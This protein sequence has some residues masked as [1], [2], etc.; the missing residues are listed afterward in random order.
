MAEARAAE[1]VAMAADMFL[2]GVQLV[3]QMS[4]PQHQEGGEL[5]MEAL[6]MKLTAMCNPLQQLKAGVDAT[7][8]NNPAITGA[9]ASGTSASRA[10]VAAAGEL[11]DS[12]APLPSMGAKEVWAED[13]LRLPPLDCRAMQ[14]ALLLPAVDVLAS[15]REGRSVAVQAWV[16]Q[17]TLL[18]ALWVRL[19]GA[20]QGGECF[21]SAARAAAAAAAAGLEAETEAVNAAAAAGVVLV[22]Q[23]TPAEAYGELPAVSARRAAAVA[24]AAQLSASAVASAAISTVSAAASAAA[25]IVSA[26]QR[27]LVEEWIDDDLFGRLPGAATAALLLPVDGAPSVGA[28]FQ[29]QQQKQAEEKEK[30]ELHGS[31]ATRGARRTAEVGRWLAV[32]MVPRLLTGSGFEKTTRGL[33]GTGGGTDEAA[34]DEDEEATVLAAQRPAGADAEDST[35]RAQGQH[36]LGLMGSISGDDSAPRQLPVSMALGDASLAPSK[37]WSSTGA[38]TAIATAPTATASSVGSS[39]RVPPLALPNNGDTSGNGT[40]G[41]KHTAR[42]G[43]FTARARVEHELHYQQRLWTDLQTPRSVC[44][45]AESV[46]ESRSADAALR[47]SGWGAVNTGEIANTV[48]DKKSGTWVVQKK[49]NGKGVH[50]AALAVSV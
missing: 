12:Q 5:A 25:L 14:S 10:G 39:S 24:M 47:L 30:V 3:Q 22:L 40:A 6:K 21:L 43:T 32:E 46:L 23:A 28:T 11:F 34:E 45:R 4:Q 9:A 8:N 19:V 29:Y 50:G 7:D 1:A 18:R 33:G 27:S 48:F 17:A 42:G 15:D 31:Y 13:R 35:G 2:L 38:P 26:A 41:D 16:I 37:A 20:G 36:V 44:R 49:C